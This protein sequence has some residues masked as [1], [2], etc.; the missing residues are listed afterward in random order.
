MLITPRAVSKPQIE[1]IFNGTSTPRSIPYNIPPL[2]L[3]QKGTP[4][5]LPQVY[6]LVSAP[7]LEF[8]EKPGHAGLPLHKAS[9]PADLFI[10]DLNG[11]LNARFPSKELLTAC[12][13]CTCKNSSEQKESNRTIF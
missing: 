4:I 8:F 12:G 9:N 11:N 1:D 3:I 5:L 7:H 10:P 6:Y 2:S 13:T